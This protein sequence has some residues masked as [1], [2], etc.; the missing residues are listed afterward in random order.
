MK[1]ITALSTW[2]DK[3]KG[4]PPSTQ[5]VCLWLLEQADSNGVVNDLSWEDL[6]EASGVSSTYLREL[7]KPDGPIVATGLVEREERFLGENKLKPLFRLAQGES[8]G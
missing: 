7:L 8:D 6:A 2:V 1:H 3:L 4:L 5:T